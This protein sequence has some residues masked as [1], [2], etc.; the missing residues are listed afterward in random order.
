MK[1]GKFPLSKT[2]GIIYLL[3]AMYPTDSSALQYNYLYSGGKFDE[4]KWYGEPWGDHWVNTSDAI[5]IE[6]RSTSP[7]PDTLTYYDTQT[8]VN[9]FSIRAGLLGFESDPRDGLG[10]WGWTLTTDPISGLPIQW[11][12]HYGAEYSVRSSQ[13]GDSVICITEYGE[14]YEAYGQTGYWT[15]TTTGTADPSAVPEPSTIL[16]LGSGLA[17]ILY[18]RRRA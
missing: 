7:L 17:C 3:L 13:N 14:G 4:I 11:D 10:P 2:L 1:T 16:L 8:D 12:I 18:A 9:Y 5:S 15:I 6:I